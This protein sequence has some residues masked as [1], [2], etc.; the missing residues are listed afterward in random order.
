MFRVTADREREIVLQF[1]PAVD[2]TVEVG[3]RLART[4]WAGDE[5]LYGYH[6]GRAVPVTRPGPGPADDPQRT[7]TAMDWTAVGTTATFCSV[8][9]T[10][11]V[12]VE[13]TD[14]VVTVESGCTHH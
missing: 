10:T 7:R 2:L 5:T 12:D 8:Y 11:A 13:A 1:R 4:T 14:D 9:S 6:V 3:P